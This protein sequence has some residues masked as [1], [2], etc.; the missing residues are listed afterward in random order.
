LLVSKANQHI[1]EHL[2]QS[3]FYMIGARAQA[4]FVNVRVD[5]E[6]ALIHL[7]VEVGTEVVDS[8]VVHVGKFD[9]ISL[10]PQIKITPEAVLLGGTKKGTHA[11][12]WL[13]PDSVYWHVARGCNYLEGFKRHEQVC[14]YDLLY[15][16][17]ATKQDSYQRLIAKAHH[18]R[19][20]VLSEEHARK[21]GAHP[22]DEIIL[23][24]FDLEPFSLQQIGVEDDD[25]TLFQGVKQN[26]VVADAEKAFVKLLDPGYNVTKFQNYP[27]GNDGL[28]DA[29]LT[30]YGYVLNENIRFRT[31]NALFKGFYSTVAFDNRQDF[32]FVEGDNVMLQ[33]GDDTPELP[34]P[35]SV[36]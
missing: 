33:F 25:F 18:G 20:R 23:F 7:D 19:L 11:K 16:G 12:I 6:K 27:K 35:T 5:K 24:L 32:I 2:K 4:S 3:K 22:S 28:Y 34:L 26:R 29:G 31:A 10:D 15:V 9:G 14:C 17:I 1:A 8:G 36:I 30:S 13:T 21:P